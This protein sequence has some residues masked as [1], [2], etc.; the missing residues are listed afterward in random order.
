[1]P[2]YYWIKLYIEIL[3]DAKMGRLTDRLFRRTIQLF[4]IAGEY[5]REGLLPPTE[6]IAWRLR[7]MEIEEL[8]TDMADLASV[9]ILHKTDQ[10][11]V[12]T[13]FEKRQAKVPVAKRMKQYRERKQ[14]EL[15]YG[16]DTRYEDVTERNTE[17]DTD[18]D[19]DID[20]EEEVD[21]EQQQQPFSQLVTTFINVSG[22]AEFGMK[23]K[24]VKAGNRMVKNGITPNDIEEGYRACL[25]RYGNPPASLAGVENSANIAMQKRTRPKKG[26]E[27]D[28]ISEEGRQ[29]YRQWDPLAK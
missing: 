24:D 28:R 8:E 6:D 1:M 3:D 19:T 5:Q 23:P 13:H 14:Q 26:Q 12:V 21:V 10:G 2:S 22:K 15:Y 7:P 25:D 4:L 27:K 20:I 9:G 11:W 29:R 16:D 18:I 17:S